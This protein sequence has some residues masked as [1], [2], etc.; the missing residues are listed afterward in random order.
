VSVIY[1]C[2]MCDKE[3]ESTFD[4]E[5]VAAAEADML[6]GPEWRN[7]PHDRVCNDCWKWVNDQPEFKAILSKLAAG[8]TSLEELEKE[9]GNA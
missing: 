2:S 7:R 8:E 9:Y 3:F 6:Y 1:Q 4:S 5:Q